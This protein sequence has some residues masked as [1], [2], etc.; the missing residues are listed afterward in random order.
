MSIGNRVATW[1][2][3]W[4]WLCLLSLS[5]SQLNQTPLVLS[6]DNSLLLIC[7][8]CLS[9]LR[10]LPFSV[11]STLIYLGMCLL[12]LWDLIATII[13]ILG[14]TLFGQYKSLATFVSSVFYFFQN[15]LFCIMYL[16]PKVKLYSYNMQKD[17]SNKHGGILA[18]TAERCWRWVKACSALPWV[19]FFWWQAE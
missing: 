9:I 1:G 17:T 11:V 6:N 7:I 19:L 10:V 3:T 18:S 13:V 15:W 4:S 16:K 14:S 5:H 8:S 2:S 12:K